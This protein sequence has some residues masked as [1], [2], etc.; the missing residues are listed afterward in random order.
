MSWPLPQDFNEAIQ[1]PSSAFSDPEL[2]AGQ[3]IVGP[4]GLPLPRS[5][6]FA[7]VYQIRAGDGR[8]WAVKCFTRPVT[9]LEERYAKVEEAL[10]RAGL[11]FTVGFT[12]QTE[13]IRVRG[14]ARPILRMEWVDG[15]LLN[16]VARDQAGTPKVLDALSQMWSR[17][18]RR[19]R[20]ARIA[21]ADLQHGNVLLVPGSRSGS[22][23]LKL[24]DYD[25]MY[26]PALAN[27]PSG[28]SGHPNFQHPV[29]AAKQI[30][31]P[32]LDRFPHL[33]IATALKGL[34]VLGPTLWDRFD[35]GDNLLFTD[36]DFRDPAASKL[37]RE[38]WQSGQPGLQALVGHLAI[39]C[40]KSIP[41]TPWLDHIA[42]D[43]IV[44]PL[45]PDQA[46]EAATALGLQPVTAGDWG[47]P[48]R[49]A[50]ASGTATRVA[51]PPA[52]EVL[53]I[54]DE[55]SAD[56]DFDTSAKNLSG[57]RPRRKTRSRQPA[58]SKMSAG[59]VVALI[60]GVFLV[61]GGIGAAILLRGKKPDDTAPVKPI[62]P[63]DV[64]LSGGSDRSQ[65]ADNKEP[66]QGDPKQTNPLVTPPPSPGGV[67]PGSPGVGSPQDPATVPPMIR[68]W[69][70]PFNGI[71]TAMRLT[72]NGN[73]VIVRANRSPTCQVYDTR[74]GLKHEDGPEGMGSLVDF[75]PLAD[76]TVA[77]W[78]ADEP[79]AFVWSPGKSRANAG[80]PVI[81]APRGNGSQVFAVSPDGKYAI[82]GCET[83]A[84]QNGGPG[85]VKVYE[86]ETGRVLVTADV[87][88][89]MFHFTRDDRLLI[90]DSNKLRWFKL[91]SGSPDGTFSNTEKIIVRVAAISA[92]GTWVLRLSILGMIVI[93]SRTGM[94]VARMESKSLA[95][96]AAIS[97]D[98][99]LVAVGTFGDPAGDRMSYMNVFH[100]STGRILGRSPI[101]PGGQLDVNSVQFLRDGKS[102]VVGRVNR[103]QRLEWS[104]DLIAA[105]PA[106]GKDPGADLTPK[107]NDTELNPLQMGLPK[108]RWTITVP[109]RVG[110][111]LLSFTPDGASV[112]VSRSNGGIRSYS[113]QTGQTLPRVDLRGG[114][115][116]Q[117]FPLQGSRVVALTSTD[118]AVWDVSTGIV[119]RK[120]PIP[121]PKPDMRPEMAL[122]SPDEKFLVVG[123]RSSFHVYEASSGK[124][125]ISNAWANESAHFTADSSRILVSQ[126]N[127]KLRWYKLPSGQP[128]GEFQ[129]AGENT[130]V[131]GISGDGQMILFHGGST[132][133]TLDSGL[134]LIDGRSG[135][136][137]HRFTT[138]FSGKGAITPDG[139]WSVRFSPNPA[140]A[141]AMVQL[142]DN[143][144]GVAARPWKI[145]GNMNS[146][147]DGFALAPDARSFAVCDMGAEKMMVFDISDLGPIV[148]AGPKP[149][150]P[151]VGMVKPK[152]P[153]FTP[154]RQPPR[155]NS[156]WAGKVPSGP[157]RGTI[158]FDR[159]GQF[160]MLGGANL[161]GVKFYD[162][163]TG[164]LGAWIEWGPQ[165]P[166]TRFI[167]LEGEKSGWYVPAQRTCY[168]RTNKQ[169]LIEKI[170]VP[171]TADFSNPSVSFSPDG[172]F[173]AVWENG[174]PRDGKIDP[175]PFR[176]YAVPADTEVVK[177]TWTGGSIHFTGDSS[178]VLVS[179]GTGKFRWYKLPSGEANG[180]CNVAKEL[181]S[182][183]SRVLAMSDDG[184][185]VFYSGLGAGGVPAF[186]VIDG[187]TGQLVR[188][189]AQ[190]N[191]YAADPDLDI[192]S[193]DGRL[194]I[195]RVSLAKGMG[196]D[197]FDR[198]TGKGMARLQLPEGAT[199][200]PVACISPEG[201]RVV[202]Y[203]PE[204]GDLACYDLAGSA[205]AVAPVRKEPTPTIPKPASVG[206]LPVPE[207][208]AI[209]KADEKVR[210]LLKDKFAKKL[211]ANKKA[212][213]L[214]LIQLAE[215]SPNDPAERYALVRD[216]RDL[217]VEA[218]DP[219]LAIQAIDG[220]A[221]WFVVDEHRIKLEVLEKFTGGTPSSATL[222]GVAEEALKCSEEAAT[223]D[224]YEN[225]IKLAQVALSAARKGSLTG[226][227]IEEA[228]HRLAHTRK[229]AD[230]F[231][232]VKSAMEKL[233]TDPDDPAANLAVGRYRCLARG[234]WDQGLGHLLKGS[235]PDLKAAA[236]EELKASKTGVPDSK[237]ADCWW[238]FAQT[239]AADERRVAEARA[240][241]WYARALPG[242]MG[243]SRARAEGRLVFTL[244][245]VEYRP[246]LVA[247]YLTKERTLVKGKKG[248]IDPVV[249]V[250]GGEFA[251][252]GRPISDI[253]AKWTGVV[254]VTRPGRYKLV[255]DTRDPV[256]VTVNGKVL[257]DTSV[258][259][260]VAK[261]E[262][263]VMLTD[264][265]TTLQVEFSSKT[266]KLHTIR[267]NWVPP[268]S[269]G[270][271]LIPAEVFF[272]DRKAEAIIGK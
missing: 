105:N 171:P 62:D 167:S 93:D 154:V 95:H 32:D 245:G 251:E 137:L 21:H 125:I 267:L 19:L 124:V 54:D 145:T 127:G 87:Q 26:V 46:S 111:G 150:A 239:L 1:N 84:R 136:R 69:E 108:N 220:I 208:A 265:P 35:T 160:I 36:Q 178:R 172:R 50:K 91:P 47:G 58:K 37:M 162:L 249:D 7:D 30:Y 176:V 186:H 14:Q 129:L 29:R 109:G 4:Q 213:A 187:Q 151:D 39:A 132:A 90:A 130:G 174:I 66:K 221:R 254:L 80:F 231:G 104:N 139:R 192:C 209:A 175:L 65:S 117:P 68:R 261:P 158:A 271:E 152:E 235:H 153:D 78:N 262:A 52:Q 222:R 260:G 252:P 189:L 258:A 198:A 83:S 156:T 185:F 110:S 86:I 190:G 101:D 230:A 232:S 34:A 204:T 79:K 264:R 214:E 123:D 17:L 256:K 234:Q 51:P 13:G 191:Q 22:Y 9:G 181:L 118:V 193:R 55:P 255:A 229:A 164:N 40:G 82:A 64:A 134:F 41:Q 227:V 88:E 33:V 53:L 194:F 27:K 238:E 133:N 112:V 45:T 38:L 15:L 247:E 102:V 23:G 206:R 163:M 57:S 76:G 205:V 203:L 92:D 179:E 74:G 241:Y 266:T 269:E 242:L 140:E 215:E 165:T 119:T 182:T 97:A 42:P 168:T 71:P 120:F 6:N 16:Q 122:L 200:V 24:I 196:V 89:P 223:T 56:P 144:S 98:G 142:Y 3:P 131:L 180:E 177:G 103:L 20:E 77:S 183:T 81:D 99:Q 60:A 85:Q 116:S 138:Q 61:G 263:V 113:A 243:L 219:V 270:E 25:G 73:M 107:K 5:G 259:K 237:V 250:S 202:V 236:E 141:S 67:T 59:L 224:D 217:A 157:E 96:A 100:V 43:G 166:V 211:P 148:A 169:G 225:A 272:H 126:T 70:A 248:R 268:G 2:K 253:L 115:R 216:A 121:D 218:S 48:S 75:S 31:S 44:V 106:V 199:G 207:D 11:P 72:A 257:I 195:L 149:V 210:E 244:N 147:F 188:T 49:P 226:G 63:P 12:F 128:D 197:V 233:K 28:E 161:R 135:Q 201:R 114:P 173:V 146:R 10:A 155:L 240:R 170:L 8:D 228:E 143:R 184:K 94:K 18:A 159:T 212:L 246:G